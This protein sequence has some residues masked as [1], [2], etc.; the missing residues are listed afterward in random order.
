MKGRAEARMSGF[1]EDAEKS[2]RV[3]GKVDDVK[4]KVYYKN[5]QMRAPARQVGFMIRVTIE[6]VLLIE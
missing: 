3:S 5:S 6:S 1:A 2:F 4:K